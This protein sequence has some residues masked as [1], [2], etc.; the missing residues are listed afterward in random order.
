[1]VRPN[2]IIHVVNV[3]VCEIEVHSKMGGADILQEQ[4]TQYHTLLVCLVDTHASSVL[5]SKQLG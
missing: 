1:M 5:L 4:E 3:F 2:L